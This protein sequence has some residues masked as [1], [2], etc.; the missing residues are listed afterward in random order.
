MTYYVVRLRFVTNN[1]Y[2]LINDVEREKKLKA[3]QIIKE[4]PDNLEIINSVIN[5][6]YDAFLYVSDRLKDNHNFVKFILSKK[7]LLIEY[8][9]DK[10]KNR[11]KIAEIAIKNNPRSYKFI[12]NELKI[13]KDIINLVIN[14]SKHYTDIITL[15]DKSLLTIDLINSII[16]NTS[17][18][19][20]FILFIPEELLTKE[21]I[22]NFINKNPNNSW[23]I[24]NIL[25]KIPLKFYDN[26]IILNIIKNNFKN[27][28]YFL[29]YFDIQLND[30]SFFLK[31]LKINH[32]F[33]NYISD[34]ILSSDKQY[35]DL[36]LSDKK[37]IMEILDI[38]SNFILDISSELQIDRDRDIIIYAINRCKDFVKYNNILLY[39]QVWNIQWNFKNFEK[40]YIEI[41]E[42]MKYMPYTDNIGILLDNILYQHDILS[43]EEY[44]SLINDKYSKY[45]TDILLFNNDKNEEYI[46]LF[47]K[48]NIRCFNFNEIKPLDTDNT[49]EE[50]KD[51][52]KN[53]NINKIILWY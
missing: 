45:L 46:I 47:E 14:N 28:K 31:A 17:I 9:S 20:D 36:I 21:I 18:D 7:G 29:E 40:N 51:A 39:N 8:A 42:N 23:A 26:D 32:E 34:R 2:Q 13:N 10:L 49:D 44:K 53:E 11:F 12:S 3:E 4:N 27:L 48:Y 52:Y 19:Y 38:N 25:H 5:Q 15:F 50:I 37:F 6:N 43:D 35:S 30:K 22:I 1:E 33:I 41:L 16:N 24:R